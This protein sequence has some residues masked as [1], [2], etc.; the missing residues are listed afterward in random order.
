MFGIFKGS[1]TLSNDEALA[2]TLLKR[3]FYLH[4]VGFVFH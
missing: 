4:K 3:H 2:I 1:G